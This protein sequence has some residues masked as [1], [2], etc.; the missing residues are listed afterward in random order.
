MF[1]K[2]T[3]GRESG[4]KSFSL[5]FNLSKMYHIAQMDAPISSNGGIARGY[6]AVYDTQCFIY[7]CASQK[8]NEKGT[9]KKEPLKCV[10]YG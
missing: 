1:K 6:R 10:G 4:Q 7:P 2:M 8:N 5:T 9:M 3:R